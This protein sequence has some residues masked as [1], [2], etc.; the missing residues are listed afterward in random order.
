MGKQFVP[1]VEDIISARQLA[2]RLKGETDADTLNNILEWQEKN[3][4]YW[5]ER[6]YLDFLLRPFIML[7]LPIIFMWISIPLII[8]TYLLLVTIIAQPYASL[9]I[10]LVLVVLFLFWLLVKAGVAVK[11]IVFILLSYPVYE[12][13]REILLARPTSKTVSA[14]LNLSII[15]WVIFGVSIFTICYLF[16]I[17]RSFARYEAGLKSKLGKIWELIVLTFK[18]SLP[19]SKIL[20]YKL[21]ICKD[22]AK[23]TAALLTNLYPNNKIYFF[24]FTGHVATGVKIGNRIYVLDQK[25][26]VLEQETWLINWDRRSAKVFELIRR[27][28]KTSIK[29]I[30]KIS[31]KQNLRS[32]TKDFKRMPKEIVEEVD[33][34]IREG[35]NSVT[36]TLENVALLFDINDS[37]IRDSLLRKVELVLQKEFVGKASKIKSIDVTKKDNDLVF[38]IELAN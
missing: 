33:K 18:Q 28:G 7:G 8:Y 22:Y 17:Y 23:L 25:L 38:R 35:K 34:A 21:G 20:E 11:L 5:R 15:N 24:T 1:T 10:S 27:D 14:V 16:I 36:F 9:I 4:G 32:I 37:V 29:L 30:G 19:V 13:M 3:I 26:P 12:I 6:G 31:K 2:G